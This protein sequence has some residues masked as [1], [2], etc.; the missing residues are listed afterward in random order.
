M[1]EPTKNAGFNLI[2]GSRFTRPTLRL[3]QPGSLANK[4]AGPPE[5][6]SGGPVRF[7]RIALAAKVAATPYQMAPPPPPLPPFLPRAG[8]LP[9]AVV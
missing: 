8:S 6:R 2:G 1:N 4:N 7:V 3:F 5:E 9:K